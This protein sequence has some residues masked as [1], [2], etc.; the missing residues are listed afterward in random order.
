MKKIKNIIELSKKRIFL[1]YPKVLSMNL[2]VTKLSSNRYNSKINIKTKKKVYFVNKEG[3]NF[4]ESLNKS[5]DAIKKKL[6]KD[7]NKKNHDRKELVKYENE[8]ERLYYTE[9]GG[10]G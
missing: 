1:L 4:K 9:I 8:I 5:C 6:E 2:T 10:E 3:Q 7:K